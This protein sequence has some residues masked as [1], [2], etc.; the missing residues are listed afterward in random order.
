MGDFVYTNVPGK[1]KTLLT[2]IR[3]VGVPSKVTV[4]WLKTVGFTSSND[5]TLIGVLKFV[6]LIDSNAAPTATW[7][8][9]RGNSHK[10]VLG[11]AIRLGYAELFALYPDAE[12]RTQAE[13]DHVFRTSS[14]GGKQVISKTIATFKALA[15]E[16]EFS[17]DGTSDPR[18]L[19]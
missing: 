1:L 12:R 6:N 5:N 18:R 14:T 4:Q 10:A 11:D 19:C 16:A 7:T 2:K 17:D 15:E 13:L 8:Q 3:T 9:F